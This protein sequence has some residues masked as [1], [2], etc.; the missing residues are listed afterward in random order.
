MTGV[1][2][3]SFGLGSPTTK[4]RAYT[5]MISSPVHRAWRVKVTLQFSQ[6][7][8]HWQSRVYTTSSIC[9]EF[10]GIS[11]R[12]CAMNSSASTEVLASTSTRSIAMIGISASIT[13]RRELAN[14]SS[15]LLRVKS[16]WPDA[17]W[18][19]QNLCRWWLRGSNSPLGRSPE[20]RPPLVHLLH[21][22]P[23]LNKNSRNRGR[24]EEGDG[25]NSETS[26]SVPLC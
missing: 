16:T 23:S 1:P 12:R 25:M 15:T 4:S 26:L 2:T 8:S 7:C 14:A 5:F 11:P 10:R 13:R 18:D 19:I 20:D 21:H 17:A 6:Y 9:L 3:H 24:R 22:N